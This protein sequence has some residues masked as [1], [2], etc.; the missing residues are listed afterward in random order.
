MG[1]RNNQ[2][3]TIPRTNIIKCQKKIQ[4]VTIK[5]V[6][7]IPKAGAIHLIM[8][9]R[10][11]PDMVPLMDNRKK[12]HPDMQTVVIHIALDKFDPVGIIDQRLKSWSTLNNIAKLNIGTLYRFGITTANM[13]DP[14]VS[15]L[16]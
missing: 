11:Q 12:I 6:V 13:A 16:L 4:I 8:T 14:L 5:P 10:M 9:T 2:C 7:M 15:G 3:A 1:S